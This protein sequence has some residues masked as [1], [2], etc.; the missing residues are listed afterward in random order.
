M[1][2]LYVLIGTVSATYL[3]T[4]GDMT[5]VQNTGA[6]TAANPAFCWKNLQAVPVRTSGADPPYTV[7]CE[8]RVFGQYLRLTKLNLNG[9]RISLYELQVTG[10]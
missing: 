7:N 6:T 1:L 10:W 4:V 5:T 8:S 9:A 2:I 3:V